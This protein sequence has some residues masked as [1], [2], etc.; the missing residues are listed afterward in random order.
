MSSVKSRG[1][2]RIL[3]IA[4]VQVLLYNFL[5]MVQRYLLIKF[6]YSRNTIQ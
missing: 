6:G 5:Y 2:L 4:N 1:Y 3:N